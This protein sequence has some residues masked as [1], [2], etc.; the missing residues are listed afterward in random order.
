[1]FIMKIHLNFLKVTLLLF[2]FRCSNLHLRPRARQE[3]KLEEIGVNQRIL[4]N[5]NMK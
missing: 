4:V 5:Y 1:M 2:G 3:L